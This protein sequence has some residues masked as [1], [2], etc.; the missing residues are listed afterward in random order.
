MEINTKDFLNYLKKNNSTNLN[1]I[2]SI[3][4]NKK[5]ISVKITDKNLFFNGLFTEKTLYNMI[6]NTLSNYMYFNNI[7]GSDIDFLQY[8][9][10][11][12]NIN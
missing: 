6:I 5:S 7:E 8:K 3:R 4:F 10:K 2:K 11:K 12:L 1:F 9:Y